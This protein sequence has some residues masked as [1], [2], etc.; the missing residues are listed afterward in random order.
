MSSLRRKFALAAL[1]RA[2]NE[3]ACIRGVGHLHVGSVGC[4]L[5]PSALRRLGITQTLC[6]GE[7][8]E[9]PSEEVMIEA[10]IDHCNIG[11]L[12]KPD[13]D[14]HAIFDTC[15]DI[16]E[17]CRKSHGKILVYCFQGKSRSIT[18]SV[19]YLMKYYE[20][21]FHEALSVVREARPIASPNLGFIV[22]LRKYSKELELNKSKTNQELG[23][24]EEDE[25]N[26]GGNGTNCA[27]YDPLEAAEE[28]QKSANN[29]DSKIGSS[30]IL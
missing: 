23:I 5:N 17:Q 10:G 28:I 22:A 13:V 9:G 27:K 25:S 29:V 3:P 2:D 30:T 7:G 24:F 11:V 12:D 14:I 15:F 6:V 21:T 18:I 20:L 4:I 16:I 26:N 8:V 19:A 1:M